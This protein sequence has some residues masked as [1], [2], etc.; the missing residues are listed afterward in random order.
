MWEKDPYAGQ[1]RGER[2]RARNL[3]YKAIKAEKARRD[4]A[5]REKPVA[6][7]G[8]A[9]DRAVGTVAAASGGTLVRLDNAE[10]VRCRAGFRALPEA[11]DA[12]VV[13]DRVVVERAP[14]RCQVVD[15][16]PRR[17]R[18]VRMRADRSRR[19]GAGQREH[20]LAANVDLAV[21]VAA[22]ASPPFHP[23]LIDRYLVMCQYG[24]VAPAICINK[25]DLA[26]DLPDLSPFAAIGVPIVYASARTGAGLAELRS[27]L[28]GKLAILTGQSGVGKS[29]LLNRLLGDEVQ[30]V[31]EVRD[32]D[33]RGRHTTTAS[34]LH[35]VGPATFLID[36]PGIRSLGLWKID[37]EE[38]RYYYPEFEALASQCRFR[39]CR[40]LSEPDCAVRAGAAAGELPD[41]RYDSY[42]R[43]MTDP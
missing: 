37:P 10:L 16:E 22:A 38:L 41:Y 21:I 5:R 28:T 40:H 13:G 3:G 19:S 31:G 1:L 11:I 4:E 39:D 8:P 17:S 26:E 34:S 25:C 7:A 15:V 24:E 23:R 9:T 18:L 12:L 20:V 6:R 43:L 42:R 32:Y 36:T 27:L 14:D 33:G 35:E 29:A 30:R 2:R